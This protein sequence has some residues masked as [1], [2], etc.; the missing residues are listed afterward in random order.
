MS[1][2]QPQRPDR[3]RPGSGPAPAYRE[4][5]GAPWAAWPIVGV[6]ALSMGLTLLPVHPVAA[7]AGLVVTAVGLVALLRAWRLR[8]EV[9]D[10]HLAVG[11][12]RVPASVL[13]EVRE[14]D[15]AAMRVERGTGLDA[16][17]W[18]AIRGWVPTGVRVTLLDPADPTPYWLVSS[19]D[20]A[21]LARAVRQ[22]RAAGAGTSDGA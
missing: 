13:G 18:L 17:A 11:R 7:L 19:R 2:S 12:A 9:A 6:L 10:G 14:L 3:Q 15:A 1:T 4:T 22:A 5:V 16:R 20:P 8:V 21:G